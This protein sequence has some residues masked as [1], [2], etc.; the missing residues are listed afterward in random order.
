MEAKMEMNLRILGQNI[1]RIRE[2]KNISLEEVSLKT[3]IRKQYLEK[4]ESGNAPRCRFL[5]VYIIAEA[6]NTKPHVLFE[7]I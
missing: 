6:L 5:Q 7:G 1:K 2:I 3:G 4:I